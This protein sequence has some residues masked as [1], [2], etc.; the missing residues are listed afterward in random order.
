MKISIHLVTFI[1][2]SSLQPTYSQTSKKSDSLLKVY[3]KQPDDTTK[4]NILRDLYAIA[5]YNN[6]NDAK[7][8]AYEQLK[9]S[10]K[11]NYKKGI[12]YAYYNIGTYNRNVDQG[13]SAK[14]YYKKALEIFGTINDRKGEFQ[15]SHALATQENYEGNYDEAI[16]IANKNIKGRLAVNDSARL[17]GVYIFRAMVYQN[18][19]SFKIAYD[20][21]LAALAIYEK[22]DEPLWKADAL[23]TLLALEWTFKNYEKAIEH[24]K[25][26]LKIYKKHDDKVF[27]ATCSNGIGQVYFDLKDYENSEKYLLESIALS[28]EMQL[29]AM[30]GSATRN[31][32]GVYIAQNKYEK[33]IKYLQAA[34]K[35]HRET[36]RPVELLSTLSAAGVANNTMNLPEK[37]LVYFNQGAQLFESKRPSG[38]AAGLYEGRSKSYELMKN[39]HKALYDYKEFKALND[40]VFDSDKTKQIEELRTIYDTEKKEQQIVLQ[41]K[42]IDLL[43]EKAKVSN[44]QRLLLGGG[45]LLSLGVVGFGFYG[46]RQKIKRNKL[47]KEKVDAEL[48]FKKKELTTHALHLAKKN[49]TLE[50]L[51]QKAEELKTSENSGN[52]YQ[53]LIRTINFDLQNDNNWENFSKYFQEVHKDFNSNIKQK[54][55]EV[56]SNEIRLM[57]LLKMNLSSKEIANILN[58]SQEGIKKA[59]Y[60]LRKKLNITTED[61][62]QDLVL[63]L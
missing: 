18:K 59:R 13:D 9:L 44:L 12:G 51:K 52:G 1:L 33:G 27:Q 20:D 11:L 57:S 45:L 25:E 2:I 42:E 35:I 40:S 10:Q 29:L 56:T 62:L 46:F 53:Q 43:E 36:D 15:T 30:E 41:E 16:K 60:R 63:S 54:F 26:A 22:I 21:I 61:S 14:S 7:K 19:G 47:E 34:I 17:A 37:A 48:A 39:Y 23:N 32:G 5:L 24:G 28:K 31:L 3:N 38:N 58:I 8:Y 6:I 4:V 49:E 50:S 55:P